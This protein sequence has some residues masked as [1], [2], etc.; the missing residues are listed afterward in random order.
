MDA[1]QAERPRPWRGEFRHRRQ[2]LSEELAGHD[3]KVP[4]WRASHAQSARA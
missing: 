2:R 3:L 1:H 4:M